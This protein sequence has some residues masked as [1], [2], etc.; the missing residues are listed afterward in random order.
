MMVEIS[1]GIDVD[2][3]AVSE[4]LHALRKLLD[5]RHA[6]AQDEHWN[7][8]PV[9]AQRGLNLDTHWVGGIG[10]PAQSGARSYPFWPDNRQND[11]ASVEH[12]ADMP[13]EVDAGRDVVDVAEYR[14]PAVMR[15]EPVED[16]SG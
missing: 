16:P 5:P 11:V 14:V 7:Y 3:V 2:R 9:L 13:P 12:R 15:R 4:I 8:R 1:S 10:E 6:G